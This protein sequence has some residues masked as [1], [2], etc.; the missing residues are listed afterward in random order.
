MIGRS[1]WLQSVHV[2]TDAR[3][4][5]IIDVTLLSVYRQV[6]DLA[7]PGA[8]SYVIPGGASGDPAAPH[9]ADQLAEWA[10]HRRVPML[11]RWEDID[12]AARSRTV[13]R[14]ERKDQ[15]P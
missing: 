10:R 5:D 3:A 13:L 8:A 14:P 4:G 15:A 2:E 9:F 12:A 6:V 7:A 11:W 1:P